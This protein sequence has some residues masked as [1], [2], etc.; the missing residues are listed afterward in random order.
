MRIN[1]FLIFPLLQ[2]ALSCVPPNVR[3]Q[4][5]P[6][7]GSTYPFVIPGPEVTSDDPST[8]GYFSNHLSLNTNNLTASLDFYTRVFGYRHMFTFHATDVLSVTYLGRSQGGRNG[9]AFQ[10]TEELLRNKQN[11]LGLL[12]IVYF[13][14]TKDDVRERI[15]GSTQ[16]TST[17]S[18]LG[19]IVPDPEATQK[20]LEDM[21]VVVH[22]KLGAPWPTE[23]PLG[24]PN[25]LGDASGLSDEGWDQIRMVW[26]Q[27]N[28][29][30]IFAEDPDGNLLEIQPFHEP[31]LF[32]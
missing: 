26:G 4:D 12:E 25:T 22:K 10:T 16:R 2:T 14:A 24:T 11:S 7:E 29:L 19:I 1:T 5:A 28:L 15:P 6:Q 18:H 8:V 20:R 3:R 17:F 21:N 30:N 13:N 31:P 9:S 23:G 27:L 32:G